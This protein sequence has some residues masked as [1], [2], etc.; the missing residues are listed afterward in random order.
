VKL[1]ASY[2][3]D[4]DPQHRVVES[5]CRELLRS[6]SDRCVFA[7]DWPHTRFSGLDVGPYLEAILDWIEDEDVPLHKVLVENA[8]RLFDAGQASN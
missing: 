1:S 8:E 2:R 5:L 3:L 7:T 4:S 6:R